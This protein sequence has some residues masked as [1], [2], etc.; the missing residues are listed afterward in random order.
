[1]STP[2]YSQQDSLKLYTISDGSIT[3]PYWGGYLPSADFDVKPHVYPSTTWQDE[4]GTY[5]FVKDE[6]EDFTTFLDGINQLLPRLAPNN[7]VRILWIYNADQDWKQ[8][9]FDYF[10]ATATEEAAGLKWVVSRQASFKIGTYSMIVDA[11]TAMTLKSDFADMIT[12][13]KDWVNFIGAKGI[14]PV[15]DPNPS[16]ALSG[17]GI[18]SWKA[19]FQFTSNDLVDLGLMMRYATTSSTG[20]EDP[21]GGVEALNAPVLNSAEEAEIDVVFYFDP[22]NPL[23]PERSYMDL[24]PYQQVPPP[25]ISSAFTTVLGFNVH[26]TPVYSPP[27]IQSTKLV[28]NALPSAYTS[29]GDRLYSDYY[30]V[31][32][33]CFTMSVENIT[34]NTIHQLLC[35]LSGVEYIEFSN[36]DTIIFYAGQSAGVNVLGQSNEENTL[37]LELSDSPHYTTAWAMVVAQ[38]NSSSPRTYYSEGDKAPF[39]VNRTASAKKDLDYYPLSIKNLPDT[40]GSVPNFN[41][42]PLVPYSEM[43]KSKVGFGSEASDVE[44]F[45]FQLLNPTRQ[46]RIN[47][48]ISDSISESDDTVFSL[49]PQGYQATFK[50]GKW[51]GISIAK[52]TVM[53]GASN[54]VTVSNVDIEFSSATELPKPLQKAFLTN[55]QFLVMTANVDGNLDGFAPK[56]VM[57]DWT[58]DL[59]MP[60]TT[61]PGG[62]TNVF[63]FKSGNTSIS[64]MVQKPHLWTQRNDFNDKSSDQ[65]GTFLSNWLVDYIEEAKALWDLGNGVASLDNFCNAVTD[66]NWNGFL[67]LKVAVGT[68]STLPVDVQAIMADIKG[69]LYAHHLGNELNHIKPPTLDSIQEG[70]VVQTSNNAFPANT[71]VSSKTATSLTLSANPT[72]AIPTGTQIQLI[73]KTNLTL[74]AI[75]TTSEN[76]IDIS[77]VA[78]G[79]I[80]NIE[81]GATVQTAGNAFP[82]NTV[83][84]TITATTLTFSE[85]PNTEVGIGTT[86]D[87]QKLNNQYDLTL[88]SALSTSEDTITESE[89]SVVKGPYDLNSPFFG[90]IH[91][92]NPNFAGEVKHP[93]AYVQNTGTYDF[94]VLTLEVTFEKV[95]ETHFANKSMLLMNQLFGDNT[96]KYGPNGKTGANNLILIGTYHHV[97]NIPTYS[98]STAKGVTTDFYM[99][100]NAFNCIRIADVTMNVTVLSDPKNGPE[101]YMASFAI[102][103]SFDFL[104]NSNFDLLSYEYLPFY[105]LTMDVTIQHDK[106]NL[107]SMGY[108][109]FQFEKNRTEPQPYGSPVKAGQ[110][111]NIVRDSSLV[112]QFPL[113]LKGLIQH[114][115]SVKNKLPN[116]VSPKDMGYRLL[117]T[118]T[119]KVTYSSPANGEGWYGLEFDLLLG[120]KGGLAA[121]R[122]ISASMILA[123]KHGGNGAANASPQFKLSGPD[124]VSLSFDF[125]GVLKFGAKDIMLNRHVDSADKTKDYFYLV[126]QSIALTLLDISLPPGGTTNLVLMGDTNNTAKPTLS[127]FGGYAK[128]QSNEGGN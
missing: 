54:D 51:T 10:K 95:L 114:V 66:K 78:T 29:V 88:S 116:N 36:G 19:Y 26:L 105:G 87:F 42:F 31:P 43:T 20:E 75:L 119:S 96:L 109:K 111:F 8:W 83:V 11:G 35:G 99:E 73:Q 108:S 40:M 15:Q 76:T 61:T 90:L 103:G 81:V 74:N 68:F 57:S 117:E 12:F 67:A 106:T 7:D 5:L 65:N 71:V 125:E 124:G 45:E 59:D 118:T 112:A 21:F 53:G 4:G 49:T 33:G 3:S 30:L 41:K 62:Y 50:G 123:W 25:K 14:Y 86:I 28:F 9:Q 97:D 55:Q 100:S 22:L 121:G 84:L 77:E 120:G 69:T 98:F 60:T 58:F 13:P 6:P 82:V 37:S 107:Y 128:Q 122:A 79:I 39:F 89:V 85:S 17:K 101:I 126:F 94:T 24:F 16:L 47:K 34:N 32:H 102:R 27:S 46:H 127:W 63:I 113:K 64:E 72:I 93:P 70:A 110:A 18:G 115:G 80:A 44:N 91:Y 56:V 2:V 48:M 38:A 92:V 104:Y 1:M 52:A 23:D